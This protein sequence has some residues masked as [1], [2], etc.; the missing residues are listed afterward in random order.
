MVVQRSM[1][2]HSTTRLQLSTRSIERTWFAQIVHYA[3]AVGPTCKIYTP[4]F[5][6][7]TTYGIPK[8]TTLLYQRNPAP[9]RRAVRTRR[10][11]GAY[12]R[13]CFSVSFLFVVLIGLAE[14]VELSGG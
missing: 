10:V 14:V 3:R 11:C 7:T 2:R 13:F 8:L 1:S 12:A 6:R 9:G 4:L 5:R